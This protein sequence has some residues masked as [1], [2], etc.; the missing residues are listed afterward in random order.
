[1]T[2]VAGVEDRTGTVEAGAG[3][4]RTAPESRGAAGAGTGAGEEATTDLARHKTTGV[5]VCLF[6]SLLT[7]GSRV[8][9]S[10]WRH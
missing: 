4:A 9:D 1:M 2:E 5:F 7:F 8:G 10:C 3:V 6:H